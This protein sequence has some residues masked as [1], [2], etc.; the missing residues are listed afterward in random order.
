MQ[1]L[2]DFLESFRAP[3][4]GRMSLDFDFNSLFK[5][6]LSTCFQ[7]FLIRFANHLKSIFHTFLSFCLGDDLK[8]ILKPWSRV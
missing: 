1:G 8:L 3:M 5:F 7:V 4:P 2:K 6:D